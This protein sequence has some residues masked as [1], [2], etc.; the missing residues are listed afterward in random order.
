MRGVGRD[1]LKVLYERLEVNG[2]HGHEVCKE[3]VQES[4]QVA[5]RRVDLNKRLERLETAQ[6]ELDSIGVQ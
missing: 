4:V 1:V 2:K 5:D 6:G 3:L